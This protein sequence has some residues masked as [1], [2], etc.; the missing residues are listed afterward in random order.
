MK[1]LTLAIITITFSLTLLAQKADLYLKRSENGFY[2]EHKVVAKESFFSVGRLYNVH[3][4][5]VAS[6]NKMDYN[7]GLFL[8]KVIRIPLTDTNFTQK[9]N[10]GTPLYY[11]AT[12][13]DDW[14]SIGKNFR[15]SADK[16]RTWNSEIKKGQK[17]VV[18]LLL[19]SEMPSQAFSSKN[20]DANLAKN[21]AKEEKKE[22][23]EE[24]KELV[25]A[26]KVEEK[27]KPAETKQEEKITPVIE[28]KI[29]SPS[30]YEQGYFKAAFEQQ[31]RINAASK[32]ETVTAG[33][34]KTTSGWQDAKYY[35]LIDAVSPGTIVRIQNPSNNRVIFAKVLG[36]MSGIRLN[37]GL[38]T[39]ISNAAAAALDISE[40]DKFILKVNY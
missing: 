34:F 28:K 8:D 15:V 26:E 24:K 20:E 23:K 2:L 38:N 11:K 12:E 33:I 10:K 21:D 39:R 7:K 31:V 1:K 40:T 22:L 16:L 17:V 30:N 25:A 36:E 18:G 6:Y 37:D 35:L 3:P 4:R 13:K 5:A 9:G 29:V 19:T 32:D 14:N 27:G